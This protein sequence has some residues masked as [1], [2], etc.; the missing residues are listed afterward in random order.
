MNYSQWWYG[1]A[2][3]SL[4]V[5]P[6]DYFG[7]FDLV[8]VDLLSFVAETIKVTAGL[9]IMDIAPLLMKKEGG[10]VVR[11]ED[12]QDRSEDARKMSKHVIEYDFW[13]L[14]RLCEQSVTLGSDSIDFFSTTNRYNHGVDL[15][16]RLKDFQNEAF[17]SWSIYH[18][19]TKRSP[20]LIPPE[21]S[22][23]GTAPDVTASTTTIHPKCQKLQQAAES[24]EP[25][26][27]AP[28]VGILMIIEAE[29]VN[30]EFDDENNNNDKLFK[31]IEK[32]LATE[33]IESNDLNL[34]SVLYQ[35]NIDANTAFF[36][37]DEC[38]IKITLYSDEKYVAFDLMMWNDLDKSSTIKEA[39]VRSVGGDPNNGSTSAFRV[40]TEGMSG[41]MMKSNTNSNNLLEVAETYFCGEEG[42][43]ADKSDNKSDSED[44]P[45]EHV[46]GTDTGTDIGVDASL[47]KPEPA[48]VITELVEGFILPNKTS[49]TTASPTAVF[50]VFCGEENAECAIGSGVD[51]R[52]SDTDS[53]TTVSFNTVHSCASF[54]DMHGC[55]MIV[56]ERLESVVAGNNNKRLDGIII[57][58][59][60]ALDMGKVV[61]KIFNSTINQEILT[62]RSFLVISPVDE[63]EKWRDILV[64][65]FRT[66]I[67]TTSPTFNVDI[68]FYNETHADEWCIV[69]VRIDLFY[70]HLKK[71]LMSIKDRSGLSF[72][73]KDIELGAHIMDFNFHPLEP[74]DSAFH[75]KE[76]EEQWFNQKP[77]AYQTL[78]QMETVR[79]LTPLLMN[80]TVLVVTEL[81]AANGDVS[82]FLALVLFCIDLILLTY[83][84]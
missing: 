47:L 59:S 44:D 68:E 36:I 33:A 46:K 49:S 11:N 55:E 2:A 43:A 45:V 84:S 76:A 60:V 70:D 72:A 22:I 74:K 64:D 14:P 56:Q 15:M 10:I 77:V 5:I 4:K 19:N 65:R 29:N 78:M 26:E 3:K 9:S 82:Y 17:D 37:L 51:S 40:V 23:G 62:E 34:R 8:I 73:I 7:S 69:S 57:D 54:D 13:D 28:L 53:V 41:S 58:R 61:H 63:E 25:K 39:L 79:P 80:E 20:S 67:R 24:S 75:T 81:T 83:G 31:I 42:I 1:D 50:V 71:G 35:P 66:E 18:N 12:Y 48:F 21:T 16:L 52:H 38:Y 27:K 30:L 6:K 32:R